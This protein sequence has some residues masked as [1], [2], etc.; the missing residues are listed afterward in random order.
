[1]WRATCRHPNFPALLLC[2][3]S[4]GQRGISAQTIQILVPVAPSC[5]GALQ[6]PS[7]LPPAHCQLLPL[8][9]LTDADSPVAAGAEAWAIGAS[10]RQDRGQWPGAGPASRAGPAGARHPCPP[11][12]AGRP[13]WAPAHP[14]AVIFCPPVR[15]ALVGARGRG[16]AGPGGRLWP[17][18]WQH[19]PRRG[20]QSEATAAAAASSQQLPAAA[21][22]SQHPTSNSTQH[23]TAGRVA[24]GYI[25]PHR[26]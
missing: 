22:S 6:H 17:V 19:Q 23:P 1:V 26:P 14:P 9:H 21:S 8:R 4:V 2:G 13:G 11:A 25:G 24:M 3:S 16:L 7:P 12:V 10:G 15:A 5:I 18:V 20:P